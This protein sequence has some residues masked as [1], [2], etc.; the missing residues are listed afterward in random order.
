MTFINN[1]VSSSNVGHLRN[2]TLIISTINCNTWFVVR[3][4]SG[5]KDSDMSLILNTLSFD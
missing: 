4:I 5:L 2:A 1:M 3:T